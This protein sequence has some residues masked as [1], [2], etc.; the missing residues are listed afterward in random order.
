MG[1]IAA[2]RV[3]AGLGAVGRVAAGLGAVGRIAADLAA[4]GWLMR[5]APY[6]LGCGGRRVATYKEC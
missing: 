6:G 1:R 2:G 5:E 4:A 3:A